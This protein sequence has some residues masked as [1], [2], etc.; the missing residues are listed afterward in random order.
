MF[1]RTGLFANN[2]S[3]LQAQY[4]LIPKN[5]HTIFF[6]RYALAISS[7]MHYR[8]QDLNKSEHLQII[9]LFAYFTIKEINFYITL[10]WT[11]IIF[12]HIL[13]LLFQGTMPHNSHIPMDEMIPPILSYR[14]YI[15]T[16][17][18]FFPHFHAHVYFHVH[19]VFQ[20]CRNW[21]NLGWR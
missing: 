9:D 10:K 4:W 3:T 12:I 1:A 2:R 13:T 16:F 18:L 21:W 5:R 14:N 17:V 20:L 6:Y 19:S 11:I 15:T 8:L 7:M